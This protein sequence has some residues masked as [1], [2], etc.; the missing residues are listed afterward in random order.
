MLIKQFQDMTWEELGG[1]VDD[2]M[3]DEFAIVTRVEGDSPGHVVWAG[4]A[5]QRRLLRQ[6]LLVFLIEGAAWISCSSF[7]EPAVASPAGP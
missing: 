7:K 6:T 4:D 3:R 2:E 5:T 1:K